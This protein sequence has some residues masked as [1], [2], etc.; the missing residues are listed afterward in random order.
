MF[1]I[2]FSGK[3]TLKTGNSQKQSQSFSVKGER[4]REREYWKGWMVE[5]DRIGRGIQ[6]A[7]MV[8][9]DGWYPS[10]LLFLFKFTKHVHW[11]LH[12]KIDQQ[13]N[14]QKCEDQKYPGKKDDWWRRIKENQ[15]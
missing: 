6:L 9:F 7:L 4:E 5:G 13:T 12:W 14:K 15:V 3:I 2:F 11:D 8:K 10:S 1:Q